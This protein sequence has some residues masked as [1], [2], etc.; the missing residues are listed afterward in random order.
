MELKVPPMTE[1]HEIEL[2]YLLEPY[3]QGKHDIE[4][5]SFGP[6]K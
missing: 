2:G 1:G 6:G 5:V 3:D 4:V